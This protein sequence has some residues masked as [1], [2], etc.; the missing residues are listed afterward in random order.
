MAAADEKH[1]LP[2]P[3]VDSFLRS[4][5][6][7]SG[8]SSEHAEIIASALLLADLRGVDTHGANRLPGYLDRIRAGVVNPAPELVF[9]NKTPVLVQLDAQNGLGIVAATLATRKAIEVASTYGVGI[10]AVKNSGHFGMA[11]TYLLEAVNKGYGAMVF[12]NASRSMP[13]WGSKEALLGTSPFAGKIRKA[14]RR[15]ETI[16]E[17]WALDAEG[18]NTTDPK[19]GLGGVVLPIGGPKGSGL[20][21][22]MDI[23][24]GLLSG[25]S[26]AGNVNDQYKVLDK[27][28]GVGHWIM[29][30]KPDA[31]LDSQDAYY[32]R[33][34]T[35]LKTV[36][37]S[38]KAAGVD[39]IYTPGEIEA[40]MERNNRAKG[41]FYFTTSEIDALNKTAEQWGSNVKLSL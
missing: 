13:A 20:A 6:T 38:E 2:I 4:A 16:P 14:L 21:M 34:E 22:M 29:V 12:T 35:E 23:F 18:R 33:L 40:D 36:R 10:V 28:Q 1:F 39:R 8:V 25:S 3:A 19:A 17:G 41:G 26:F 9:V 30:F 11:A 31:F 24:G 32:D 7:A 15:G 27:P 5:V 37:Q